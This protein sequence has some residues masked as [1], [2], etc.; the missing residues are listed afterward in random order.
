M[1]ILRL[2]MVVSLFQFLSRAT[3]AQPLTVYRGLLHGHTSFSD[4]Q[5]TPDEAFQMAKDA[6]LDFMACTEHN[7]DQAAGS[8]GVFLTPRLHEQLIEMAQDHTVDGE[9]IAIWGQEVST[10]SAG[11]HVNVFF[12]PK[13]CDIGGG[14]FKTLYEE[15]LPDHPEVPFIQF[16]H[17]DFRADQR[18]TTAAK[19]RNN[20]YGIDD[21]DKDFEKLLAASGRYVALIELIVGPA[22][23]TSTGKLHQQGKHEADYLFYLNQ[24]IDLLHQWGKTITTSHGESQQKREWESGQRVSP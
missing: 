7:H 12:T 1:L 3:E 8:D 17:P 10:I 19:K 24:D 18:R 4:G 20:D 11:N 14:D 2:L 23:S 6:G 21:Y 22:F 5:G 9:F 13:I 16:N 15:W